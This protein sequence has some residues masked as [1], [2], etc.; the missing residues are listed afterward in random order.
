SIYSGGNTSWQ[1]EKEKNIQRVF[2]KFWYGWFG[3][4]TNGNWGILRGVQKLVTNI[5]KKLR[6]QFRR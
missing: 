3:N 5:L 4:G 6:Q 1:D 2:P